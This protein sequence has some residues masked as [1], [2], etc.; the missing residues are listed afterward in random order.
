MSRASRQR[1]SLA[2]SLFPFLAV[3]LCTMGALVLILMLV[4]SAAHASALQIAKQSTQQ[5]EEVESQLALANHGFQ[6]QLTEARLELEKKRLGL[7]HLESHIQ[8]LL[9]EVEQLKCTAE[10]AEA[11][12]QSDEAEQQAQADAISLLEKQL[13]EASEKLKQ[14]LDKP[15]GD[16]PIFAI[17]P[18]DGP[19][20][21]HRRPIYLECIEQGIRIQ[22]EGILLRTEDLEPPYGPG[23]PLDAALRTIRTQYAPANHAVTSTAYPLLIVRP[24]GIR[25]YAMARA[26]MSGWDDQFG[27]ELMG[28]DVELT[29]PDGEPGLSDKIV[30]ALELAR[31]R[32]AALILAM[33]QKYRGLS[34]RDRPLSGGGSGS[35]TEL[36]GYGSDA[37]GGD[38]YGGDYAISRVGQAGSGDGAYPGGGRGGWADG[39]SSDAAAALQE[40]GSQPNGSSDGPMGFGEGSASGTNPA[41]SAGGESLFGSA[42]SSSDVGNS[43]GGTHQPN[44]SGY[45]PYNVS[46]RRTAEGGAFNGFAGNS[47]TNRSATG[48]AREIAGNQADSGNPS[49]GGSQASN[50]S[51]SS[52]NAASSG[53]AGGA[54]GGGGSQMSGSQMAMPFNT[55]NPGGS[56][57][58][59]SGSAGQSASGSQAG[60]SGGASGST[61]QPPDDMNGQQV[62]PQLSLNKNFN[63]Q[64]Q[65]STPP[66]A[67]RR[68]RG[69]A[70]S[71]GP[72][73]QTSVGRSIRLQCLADRWIVLPDSGKANDPS[74]ITITFDT[75]P[76][77]RAERLAQV[78][79]ERVDSWGLALSG[80]Y[81]KPTLVVDVAPDAQ[82]RFH[83]LQQLLEGSGLDV[84]RSQ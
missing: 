2:P 49:G 13:L 18:Y 69:W 50:R 24:S 39:S 26:A 12:E 19:N 35:G 7:Q 57:G 25:S 28:D 40:G 73:S 43:T 44:H 32:Q 6:K 41:G 72:P 48:S 68:G 9:D 38:G 80:G 30:R 59:S 10:L 74:A 82:W 36:G 15:D 55:P 8:E 4:V 66:V 42:G 45:D 75:S 62:S 14:K 46:S 60:A 67:S 54:S 20:G 65:E 77:Q 83:Q 52:A 23:N 33:P 1:D 11:D 21:T 3:L 5:T 17:I 16:K 78:V 71:Q 51:S 58:N 63:G 31:E 37:H 27:Y 76:Q 64:R 34:Q 81:W 56:S 70:W 53:A 61:S 79:A 47:G 84:Q 29:F 22:P